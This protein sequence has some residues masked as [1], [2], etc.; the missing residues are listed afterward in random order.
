MS[1]RLL[2]HVHTTTPPSK[3]RP[4]PAMILLTLAGGI[5]GFLFGYDTGV[6]SGALPYI[7]DDLLT[8]YRHDKARCALLQTC[9]TPAHTP[10]RLAQVQ[11]TIVSAA[12]VAA[13]IGSAFGGW[14]CDR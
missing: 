7:R 2:V 1:T 11:E 12:I 8:V 5:G 9:L 10:H 13:G 3:G 6:I 4:S 14:V